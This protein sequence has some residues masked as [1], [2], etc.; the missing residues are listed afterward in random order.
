MQNLCCI[1]M[2]RDILKVNLEVKFI[3]MK[4]VVVLQIEGEGCTDTYNTKTIS[5]SVLKECKLLNF[6]Q[7]LK[8]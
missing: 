7:D 2:E 6:L 5:Q 4:T 8:Y 1:W 3:C